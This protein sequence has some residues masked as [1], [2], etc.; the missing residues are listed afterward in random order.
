[1]AA[2][3]FFCFDESPSQ[4]ALERQE[5][6]VGVVRRGERDQRRMIVAMAGALAIA[7]VLL[8]P[9]TLA[10]CTVFNGLVPLSKSF[11]DRVT[12]EA[13]KMPV[14]WFHGMAD[15]VPPASCD[16]EEAPAIGGRPSSSSEASAGSRAQAA[17][18]ISSSR[19]RM[20]EATD[21]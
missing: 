17:A 2:I 8:Y 21:P 12:L 20:T 6:I 11:S 1:M 9:K 19:H 5:A 13:R 4:T 10:G 15:G 14:L 16:E 7:S 18:H 3:S